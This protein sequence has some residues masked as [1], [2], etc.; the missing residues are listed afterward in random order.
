[1]RGEVDIWGFVL[2]HVVSC[3]GKRVSSYLIQSL[4]GEQI[5]HTRVKIAEQLQMN[6]DIC[7]IP[8]EMR[9]N[10]VF[11]APPRRIPNTCAG[12]NWQR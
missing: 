5:C 1:M 10:A 12:T 11:A 9:P 2:N 6:L 7:A 4:K 3:H 8:V